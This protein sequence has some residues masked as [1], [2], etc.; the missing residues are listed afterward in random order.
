MGAHSFLEEKLQKL[1][2]QKDQWQRDYDRETNDR[3]VELNLLK[4]LR[5]AGL[6]ELNDYQDKRHQEAMEHK[7]KEEE[8]RMAVRV[9]KQKREQ[10]QRMADAVL[11]IQEEGRKYMEKL[12][13]RRAAMKGKKGKK[14][15]KK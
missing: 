4:E 14:G 13:L 9:D 3:D 2:A 6:Q 10:L 15:K 5:A 8:M 12:A 11:F 1:Q 7:A